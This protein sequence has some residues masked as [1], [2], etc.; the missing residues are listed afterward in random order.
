MPSHQHSPN[1]GNYCFFLLWCIYTYDFNCH[2]KILILRSFLSLKKNPIVSMHKNRRERKMELLC[3]P[4]MPPVINT[5]KIIS[6]FRCRYTSCSFFFFL[7]QDDGRNQL[8]P[9]HS[10]VIP[11]KRLSAAH[12]NS[13]QST[14]RNQVGGINIL[15]NLELWL[16]QNY[17]MICFVI[18]KSPL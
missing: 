3:H 11:F 6:R 5:K 10:S 2:T 4:K 17:N 7:A 18:V 15:L 16:D 8:V 13:W 12:A 14:K 9:D 1:Y